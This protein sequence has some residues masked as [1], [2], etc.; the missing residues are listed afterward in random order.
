[1]L[2]RFTRD[3]R[4]TVVAARAEAVRR[5][6]GWIGTEHLLVGLLE[7]GGEDV[8]VLA[9]HGVRVD[10]VRARIAAHVPAGSDDEI[11][12]EALATLGIDLDAVKRAA[13]ERFGEGALTPTRRGPRRIRMTRRGKKVLEYA[14]RAAHHERRHEITSAHVL[15]GLVREGRGLGATVL[16][17]AGV[18]LEQLRRELEDRGRRAA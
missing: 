13:E 11:D 14:V 12:A 15:L 4:A 8:R 1:M 18:D 9:D 7:T 17:E 5:G 3:A 10:D 2:E 16:T 6:D